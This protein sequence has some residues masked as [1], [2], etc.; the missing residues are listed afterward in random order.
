MKKL[1][2]FLS[3]LA[4]LFAAS[5]TRVEELGTVETIPEAEVLNPPITFHANLNTK[6]SLN[7]DKSVSWAAGDKLTVFDASGN[8]E[9]FTVEEDTD[10]FTFTT[11]GII[12]EGPYYAIAGYGSVPPSFDAETRKI[13]LG[14]PGAT[15]DG[16]YGEAD[17]IAS[18]TEGNSFSFH[19]VFVVMKMIIESDDITELAFQAEGITAVGPTSIGFDEEGALDVSYS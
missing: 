10:N 13:E 3:A 18:M 5:C 19:H 11:A 9:E 12:G 15:T 2:I 7:E 8:S 16:S 4:L 1:S 14:L 17:V 6:T